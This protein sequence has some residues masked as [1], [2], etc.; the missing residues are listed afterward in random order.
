MK[1]QIKAVLEAEFEKVTYDP[2]AAALATRGPFAGG[3]GSN[4]S[5][6]GKASSA[7]ASGSGLDI[8]RSDLAA[9]LDKNILQEL[10]NV[11]GASPHLHCHGTLGAV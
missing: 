5:G 9:V 8:P 11:E 2:T 7:G 3:G 10:T 1:P 6:G 4:T